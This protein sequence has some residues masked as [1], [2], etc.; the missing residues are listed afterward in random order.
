MNNIVHVKSS[1]KRPLLF[2][3]VSVDIVPARKISI[4]FSLMARK[5]DGSRCSAYKPHRCRKRIAL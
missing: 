5:H 2:Q 4:E 3:I 1:P